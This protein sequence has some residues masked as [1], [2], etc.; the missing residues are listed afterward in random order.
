MTFVTLVLTLIFFL[1]GRQSDA[2]ELP[3]KPAREQY[4]RGARVR[5]LPMSVVPLFRG[6]SPTARRW[7]G[8]AKQAGRERSTLTA[9]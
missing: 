3:R 6:L 9:T 5:T 1:D 2:R 8:R 7:R 4:L